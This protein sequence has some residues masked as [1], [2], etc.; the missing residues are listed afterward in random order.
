MRSTGTTSRRRLAT[1]IN[2]RAA[3]PVLAAAALGC[4]PGAAVF[5]QIPEG[6]EV[7]RVTNDSFYDGPPAI[8]CMGQVVWSKRLA[9]FDGEEIFLRDVDGTV[10][11]ITNDNVRDAFPDINDDG[12][13]VWSRA[14]GPGGTFEVARYEDGEITLLTNNAFSESSPHINNL[15]HVVWNQFVDGECADSHVF[16]F[17]GVQ[18][19]Q[20]TRGPYSN[21]GESINDLHEIVWTQYDFCQNPW[22]GTPMYRNAKGEI[23]ELTDGSDQSQAPIINNHSQIAW[24]PDPDGIMLREKG[25][26]RLITDWGGATDVNDGGVLTVNRWHDE[27]GAWQQWIWVNGIFLRL[28]ED[29]EWN[30][31]AEINGWGEVAWL[32]GPSLRA[33]I[34]LLRW[35]ST[36][37]DINGD[38]ALDGDDW[39]LQAPCLAG[40]E[41]RADG[42]TCHRADLDHSGT[43]DLKDFAHLQAAMGDAP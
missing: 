29:Q 2:W 10:I 15:G 14:V 13:I 25:V 24:G 19:E 37:A 5:G 26:N 11:R 43:V 36:N 8:N 7:V 30:R 28:S 32:A 22:R 4:W 40:P 9:G 41:S 6:W 12:V 16:Y 23:I 42:C 20:V 1:W 17:D 18:I 27:I 33:E 38:R 21:Q 31:S 34:V 3:A 39:R 35:E